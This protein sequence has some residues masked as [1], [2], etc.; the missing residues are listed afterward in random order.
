MN[1][2]K[3]KSLKTIKTNFKIN[4]TNIFKDIVNLPK[5]ITLTS[6]LSPKK[7]S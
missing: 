7:Q 3:R 6:I 4:S 1:N 5:N 2:K